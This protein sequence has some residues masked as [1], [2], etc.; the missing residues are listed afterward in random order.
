MSLGNGGVSL[1]ETWVLP[2]DSA[3]DLTGILEKSSFMPIPYD[4]KRGEDFFFLSS[5]F[6]CV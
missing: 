3:T 1:A 4:G 6:S 2:P 5:L